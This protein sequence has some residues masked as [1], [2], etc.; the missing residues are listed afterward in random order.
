M[1][2]EFLDTNI[3]VYAH[4]STAGEKRR[5]AAEL[6]LSL[7]RERRGLLSVQ[8]LTEFVV[9]VT[10]KVPRP[11]SLEDAA[12]LADDY[13]TWTVYRP[14]PEDIGRATRLACRYKISLWDALII[15]AAAQM[16]AA[17]LWSEDLNHGQIYEGVAVKN[18]F[19]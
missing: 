1:N 3:L 8:V 9:T 6:I 13:S 15:H 14:E 19:R 2:G 4:D 10:R 5:R 17:I 12:Q 16:D 7:G 18:P 11:L